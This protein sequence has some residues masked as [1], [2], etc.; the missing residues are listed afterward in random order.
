MGTQLM[1]A[2]DFG[3]E[4]LVGTL[5]YSIIGIALFGLAFFVIVKVAPFSIRK[6]IEEDQNTALAI[7][8][9]AVILGIA[10]I[11]GAGVGG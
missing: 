3:L 4:Q 7:I 2:F 8:I 11:I 6:E 9:G 10:L 5:V 1:A